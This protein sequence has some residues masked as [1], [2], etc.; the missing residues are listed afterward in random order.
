[1]TDVVIVQAVRTPMGRGTQRNGDL[2]DVHPVIL[3]A[4]VLREVTGRAAIDPAMVGDV[5]FGCVMQTGEQAVNIARQAVLAAGFPVEVPATT[6]GRQCG[7]SP[8]A[9]PSVAN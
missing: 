4:H 5:V 9:L 2:R 6:V 7:S 8:P 3:A 1:M